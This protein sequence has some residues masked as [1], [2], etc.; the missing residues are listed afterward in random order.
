MAQMFPDHDDMK[1]AQDCI[2]KRLHAFGDN[3]WVPSREEY[4][5]QLE[6][7]QNGEAEI[8]DKA[9]Y[10]DNDCPSERVSASDNQDTRKSV[11]TKR[12]NKSKKRKAPKAPK[13]KNSS[14]GNQP[15]SSAEKSVRR[16]RR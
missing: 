1:V 7:E 3:L 15:N 6:R 4:L 5:A 16:R 14:G 12:T 9:T 13:V 2:E 8:A 10:G 11:R